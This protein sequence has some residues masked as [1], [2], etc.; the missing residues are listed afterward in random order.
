MLS[1]I[2]SLCC[3]VVL[4]MALALCALVGAGGFALAADIKV[5]LTGSEAV[6]A[7]TT[8]AS[9]SGTITVGDD[10]SVSGS[11]TTTGVVGTAAHIHMAAAGQNGPVINP[12]TEAGD[13]AWAA[14]AGAKLTDEQHN[15]YK[16]GN[17]SVN[18]HSAAH[19]GGEIRSELKP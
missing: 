14:P 3:P 11:V 6:P 19:P 18:V 9:D 17:L 2:R 7:L 12:L 8:S 13:N 10:R 15:A 16:A 5:N 4:V 1:V